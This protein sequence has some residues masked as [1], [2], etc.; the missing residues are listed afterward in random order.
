MGIPRTRLCLP[1]APRLLG[2]CQFPVA[3]RETNNET[4][5]RGGLQVPF[6]FFFFLS[7][8]QLL[9][10]NVIKVAEITVEARC[11]CLFFTCE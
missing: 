10:V 2:S 4:V 6:F 1:S 9:T 5:M 7:V 11:E 3:H 8:L